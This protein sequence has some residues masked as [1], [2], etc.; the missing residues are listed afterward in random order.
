MRHLPKLLLLTVALFTATAHA[1]TP[2]PP[3]PRVYAP[4][5]HTADS[6]LYVRAFYTNDDQFRLLSDYVDLNETEVNPDEKYVLLE[7][8]ASQV[9]ELEELGFTSADRHRPH[10]RSPHLRQQR[11]AI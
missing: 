10:R 11:R 1:Q 5:I 8:N 9:K 2:E 4:I 7:I 3:Q 6:L